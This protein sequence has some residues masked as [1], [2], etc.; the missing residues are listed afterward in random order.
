[1]AERDVDAALARSFLGDLPPEVVGRLCAEG[2]RADYPAGTTVYR[3]GS[4]PQA[5]L[6]VR[7]LIRVYLAS[8]EGRQVTVRYARPGDVLGIAVLVGGPVNV[9]VQA[10]EPT[11]LFRIS[12]RMLTAAARRDQRVCW[13]IA[14]EL[15]RRLQETLEQTAV[16]AFGSV[17]QRVAAHLLDLAS[18]QQHPRGPLSARVSQQELADAAGSVREVVARALRDLRVAGIVATSADKVVILDAARLY[19]ES[20]WPAGQ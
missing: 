16:N 14:E 6:V 4:A 13:A 1:V 10:V 18:A 19:A 20:G 17:R 7:G 8:P 12:P 11:S 2:E 9:G 3:A 15:N 5:A